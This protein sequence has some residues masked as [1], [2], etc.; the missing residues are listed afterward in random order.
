MMQAR[1]SFDRELIRAVVD[2]R[3]FGSFI[4]HLGRAI[5]GGVYEPGHPTSDTEG[6]RTD[7]LDLVRELRVP[8]IRYPGGN[9]VSAFNWED[10][11]GPAAQRPRRLDLAWRS[12]EPNTVGLN[13]FARW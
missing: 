2:E 3:L 12:V 8:L 11:V 1:V 10:S 7:V 6:F 9:Y 13:E 4:E 5:Y